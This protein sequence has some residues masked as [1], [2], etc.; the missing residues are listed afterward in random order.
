M[1]DNAD[2][3]RIS[4]ANFSIMDCY[5]KRTNKSNEIDK[6]LA[7]ILKLTRYYLGITLKECHIDGL[8][9]S[10]NNKVE[11][12]RVP[13]KYDTLKKICNRYSINV[14]KLLNFANNVTLD[15]I[16]SMV[17]NHNMSALK[18]LAEDDF[19][20][21]LNTFNMLA[22]NAFI[23]LDE[24][25]MEEVLNCINNMMVTYKSFETAE[26]FVFFYIKSLYDYKSHFLN[27]IDNELLIL[28]ELSGQGKIFKIAYAALAC[29]IYFNTK[30]YISFLHYYEEL[31]WVNMEGLSSHTIR[32]FELYDTFIHN[33]E[34]SAD[35]LDDILL[36]KYEA[37][38]VIYN[39][40]L[41]LLIRYYFE[42]NNYNKVYNLIKEHHLEVHPLYKGLMIYLG[43][44]GYIKVV[45]NNKSLLIGHTLPEN[46]DLTDVY[47]LVMNNIMSGKEK[48]LDV[49]KTY[50]KE[51][52]ETLEEY[53]HPFINELLYIVLYK[54]LYK[55]TRYK[56]ALDVLYKAK[57]KGYNLTLIK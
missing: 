28:Q 5:E 54:T 14:E 26:W 45:P 11:N 57:D 53:Y 19:Y 36:N 35:H 16:M 46:Y 17:M 29:E 51:I 44:V 56:Q 8:S 42:Q 2:L 48:A 12:N 41:Y 49:V 30:K 9:T 27:S 10:Y 52:E 32:L 40:A 1:N 15:K 24:G 4:S 43:Y 25:R 39:D 6:I 7:H 20:Q 21:D 23:A 18:G 50:R 13:L 31:K 33:Y 37:Y 55:A 3:V 47:E 22:I 38:S 34:R